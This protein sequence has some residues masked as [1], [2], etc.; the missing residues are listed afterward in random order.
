MGLYRKVYDFAAKAGSLEGY[1]YARNKD[2]IGPLT[3]W[4]DHAIRDYNDIPPEVRQEF[5][6]LCDGT[7]GR[8]IQSLLPHLGEDHEIIKKLKVLV[9]GNMPSSPDDFTRKK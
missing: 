2:D 6:D 3:P 4:V 1:V 8:A 9:I 5:Q 7:V